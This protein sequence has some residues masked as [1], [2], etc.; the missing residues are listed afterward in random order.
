M[1]RSQRCG[2]RTKKS[3]LRICVC[4]SKDGSQNSPFFVRRKRF[5]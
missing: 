2:L 5:I 4:F 1:L 3:E